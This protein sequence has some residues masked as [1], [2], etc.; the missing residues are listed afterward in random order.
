[1]N[2]FCEANSSEYDSCGSF[3]YRFQFERQHKQELEQGRNLT[4]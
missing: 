3:V 2:S 4:Q 1:M